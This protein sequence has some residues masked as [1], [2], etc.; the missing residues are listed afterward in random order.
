MM[1]GDP[2]GPLSPVSPPS[3]TGPPGRLQAERVISAL[4]DPT[5]RAVLSLL[6]ERGE[7][8]ATAISPELSVSRQAVSKHLGVLDEAGLVRSRRT[9]REV[10]YRVRPEPLHETATWLHDLA[11]MWEVRLRKIKSIAEGGV[12]D[13]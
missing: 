12:G 5:R 4:S 13:G 2:I 11:V 7:S 6:A 10:R 9:G 3:L 8:T 1:V